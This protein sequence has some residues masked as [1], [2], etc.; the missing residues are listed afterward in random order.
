MIPSPVETADLPRIR[1][2]IAAAIRGSV[3]SNEDDAAFLIADIDKSLAWWKSH[4]AKA[5]HLKY[6]EAGKIAGVVLVK[7]FWNLTNLFVSPEH[8]Q[9]GIGRRLLLNALEGCRERSPRGAVLVNSSTHAV[10]FYKRMGFVQVGPG[11]DL[12]GGC[13]PFR[14]DF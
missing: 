3:A 6:V 9:Q 10:A 12:P 2:L 11:R 14:Y 1:S 5:L 8:Q 7:E 4:Q 13:V